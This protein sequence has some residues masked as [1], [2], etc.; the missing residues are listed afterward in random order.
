MFLGILF[1]LR[2]QQYEYSYAQSTVPRGAVPYA[3]GDADP[4]MME[5]M[6]GSNPGQIHSPPYVPVPY[7]T[8]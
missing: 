8:V 5:F 6:D 4:L 3:R 7:C 2:V 1:G